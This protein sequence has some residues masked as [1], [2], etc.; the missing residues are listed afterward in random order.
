MKPNAD[1]HIAQPSFTVLSRTWQELASYGR[2]LALAVMFIRCRN[3]SFSAQ[4]LKAALLIL[5]KA[6]LSSPSTCG[7]LESDS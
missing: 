7:T 5:Y 6:I 2:L 1:F 3:F 4:R